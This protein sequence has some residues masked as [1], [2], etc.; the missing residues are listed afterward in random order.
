[1]EN[2]SIGTKILELRNNAELTQKQL[3]QK[4]NM[5]QK[6][7]SSIETGRTSISVSDLEKVAVIF[8]VP[9][10]FFF[11]TSNQH[12]TFLGDL[13]DDEISLI[14]SYRRLSN[15]KKNAVAI[16]LEK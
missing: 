2:L 10:S 6:T 3:G 1:M 9:I 14:K 4:L 16:I 7:I 12:D 13:S 8:S 11:S 5:S 15:R